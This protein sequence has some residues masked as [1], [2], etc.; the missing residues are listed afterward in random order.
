VPRQKDP[1]GD[2]VT[3]PKPDRRAQIVAARQAG[4]SLRAIA[5]AWQITPERVRQILLEARRQAHG[6]RRL[7]LSSRAVNLL[8]CPRE[9]GWTDRLAFSPV[10]TPAELRASTFGRLELARVH[11]CGRRTMDEILRLRE[12]LLR[13]AWRE[14]RDGGGP[15]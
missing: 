2:P 3:A 1:L 9:L 15:P 11:G 4:Q 10:R 8:A 7:G 13:E 5:L 14:A 6:L 12:S